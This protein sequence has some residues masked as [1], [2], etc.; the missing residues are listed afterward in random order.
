MDGTLAKNSARSTTEEIRAAGVLLGAVHIFNICSSSS[1]ALSAEE[2]NWP[3]RKHTH[4]T[5][6]APG[7]IIIS[8]LERVI[9]SG[10]KNLHS[11]V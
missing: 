2:N 7:P 3:G 9:A 8:L 5:Y 10:L 11:V 6:C 1:G 4:T